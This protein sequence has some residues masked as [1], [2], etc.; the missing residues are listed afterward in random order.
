MITGQ[1]TTY[2]AL[3]EFVAGPTQQSANSRWQYLGGNVSALNL[4]ENWK[5]T[6]N[7]VIENQSQWDGNS[8]YLNNYPFVQRI[9]SATGPVPA[10]SLVIHPSNLEEAS[11][12]VAIGWK[13]TSVGTVAVNF[14]VNL[15]LPYG[16]N[17]GIDYY[18]QRGL[19]GSSRHL[20]IRSGS[21]GNG[22]SVALASDALLEMR[23][24]EM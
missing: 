21:L 3:A 24:G 4:L 16:S 9:D 18:L 14:H 23:P 1:S 13:N 15:R 20:S 2:D 12:A 11:R 10:G 6:G 19:A 17:D 22:G 8:G 7:E 5:T